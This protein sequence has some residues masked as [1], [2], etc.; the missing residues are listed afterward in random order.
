MINTADSKTKELIVK[1]V[2][3]EHLKDVEKSIKKLH[4]KC[5]ILN[6]ERPEIIFSDVY[7][8]SFS[9][10][11]FEDDPFAIIEAR[12]KWFT[13][14]VFDVTITLSNEIKLGDWNAIAFIDNIEQQYIQFDID[15][16]YDF[17]FETEMKDNICQHCNTKRNRRKIFVLKSDIDGSFKKVGS[18]CIKDFTGVD[19]T[20]FIS[21]FQHIIRTIKFF[22]EEYSGENNS[23]RNISDYRV[24]EI[25]HIWTISKKVLKIDEKYIKAKWE[26]MDEYPF[27][28]FRTN[29]GE[30]TS[31]KVKKVLFEYDEEDAYYVKPGKINNS[32]TKGLRE[33]L[34]NIK[35]RI[36]THTNDLDEKMEIENEFDLKLK[37]YSKRK[38]VR[39]FDIGFTSWIV[40][41]YLNH[42]E[43]LNAPES[44]WVGEINEKIQ[45]DVTVNSVIGRDTDFGWSYIYKMVDTNGNIYTKFGTIN[46]RY[47]NTNEIEKGSILKMSA[48]VKSHN[49]YKNIKE[50]ILGRCSK[51]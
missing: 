26:Q 46:A 24:F 41:A 35:V 15:A 8:Y 34:K 9:N 29:L 25:N 27:K 20:K 36:D 33:W 37:N 1:K 45:L 11:E 32:F 23:S 44:N 40:D 21:L 17:D 48:P 50:T 6:V 3:K 22:D 19:P 28:D 7:D 43:T 16:D 4:K 39:T 47:S 51:Y 2:L 42:L 49:E 10:G 30:A 31:D 38:R 13:I 18:T 12:Y 5:D 14:E